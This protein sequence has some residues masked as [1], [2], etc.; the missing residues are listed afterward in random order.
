MQQELR[1]V[2]DANAR[3]MGHSPS[4]NKAKR[5]TGVRSSAGRVRNSAALDALSSQPALIA[6]VIA[7]VSGS[8]TARLHQAGH[9]L[10]ANTPRR[11]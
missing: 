8:H 5:T 11:M 3:K 4:V 1:G 6:S 9:V 10:V 2:D 7:D